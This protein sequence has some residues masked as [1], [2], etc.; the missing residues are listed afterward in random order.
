MRF[1]T[2]YT[3]ITNRCNL[4]CMTCYNSSGLNRK[5]HE[6]AIE[7]I[8]QILDICSKY[9]AKCFLLAGGEPSLHS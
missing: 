8:K 6:I 4:N 3:E 7:Q 1:K 2:V 9:G 5:I